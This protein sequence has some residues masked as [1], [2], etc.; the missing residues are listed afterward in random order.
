MAKKVKKETKKQLLKDA[1]ESIRVKI[2]S[3]L[4]DLKAGLGEKEFKKRLKK[5][6]ALFSEGAVLK[7]KPAAEKK[8]KKKTKKGVVPETSVVEMTM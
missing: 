8:A 3:A 6:T 2:E 4:A 7:N 5:A 1:K